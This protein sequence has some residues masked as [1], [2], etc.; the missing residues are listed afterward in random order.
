[1]VRRAGRHSKAAGDGLISPLAAFPP[2][3]GF[4]PPPGSSPPGERDVLLK[5]MITRLT[6]CGVIC[7]PGGAQELPILCCAAKDDFGFRP[8]NRVLGPIRVLYSLSE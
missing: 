2:G 7:I 1:M 4:F 3:L 5:I 6:R 8:A